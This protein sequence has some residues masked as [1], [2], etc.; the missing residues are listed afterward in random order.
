MLTY[1]FKA[2]KDDSMK[3]L[4]AENFDDM[5]E[6]MA[7]ILIKG[8]A[9]QLKHGLLHDYE[10]ICKEQTFVRGK[11]LLDTSLKSGAL[12]RKS[13]VVDMMNIPKTRFSIRLLKL[14]CCTL[15]VPI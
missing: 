4:S 1:A 12:T 10:T 13:Y 6:L 7:A 8:I 5:K 3:E 11:I 14:Q 15:F 9:F 2:L